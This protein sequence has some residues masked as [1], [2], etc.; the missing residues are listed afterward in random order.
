MS[1]IRKRLTGAV[2]GV[3]ACFCVFI[4]TQSAQS[5]DS[6][7][8]SQWNVAP[9]TDGAYREAFNSALPV[10]AGRVGFNALTNVYP[11][12]DGSPLPVRSNTWFASQ[13]KVLQ[14]DTDGSVVTNTLA[15][16]AAGGGGAVTFAS[17]PVYVDL[18]IRF[19]A[20]SDP[21]TATILS[22]SK[23]A[24][25][26]E[27]GGKLVA[28]H[29]GGTTT[30]NSV[31]D[32]NKWHQVTVKLLN[33]KGDVLVNDALVF[34]NLTV[35]ASGTANTLSAVNFYGTGLVDDLYVS[36]GNPAYAIT[37]PTVDLPDLPAAGSNPPSD[38]SQTLIN[39]W[40]G[41]HP[42]VTPATTLTTLTQDQLSLAYLLNA[43]NTNASGQAEA[44]A[45]YSFGIAKIDVV[46]PTTLVVTLDLQTNGS[47]KSGTINGKVQLYGK[48]TIGGDWSLLPGAITPKY[49]DFTDGQATYTFTIPA[50][51]YRFFKP[52]IVP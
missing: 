49:L 51:G 37:G 24:L 2:E 10:W 6:V 4:L 25:F 34:S 32:T 36:H 41:A 52:Q 35:N 50:G 39:A 29:S 16:D 46:S 20:M 31:F 45:S 48:T 15:Y 13:S 30:N 47:D 42:Q 14:L 22:N 40:L 26:V 11:T 1:F 19:E 21:P 12:M 8:P 27:P 23:L 5:A 18:R 28:F 38:E 9:M 43:F 3:L 7:V 17:A 33:G 44:V